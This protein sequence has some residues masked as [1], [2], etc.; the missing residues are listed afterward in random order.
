MEVLNRFRDYHLMST[1]ELERRMGEVRDYAQQVMEENVLGRK[2]Y[3]YYK[4]KN[5]G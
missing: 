2:I 3:Q 5:K 1:F 4:K